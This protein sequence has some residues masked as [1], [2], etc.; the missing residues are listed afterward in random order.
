[1][2]LSFSRFRDEL[3]ITMNNVHLTSFYPTC[4]TPFCESLYRSLVP[5]KHIVLHIL[6][7]VLLGM[8]KSFIS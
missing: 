3:S 8:R 7:A 5:K 2:T 1:M 6:A 4:K